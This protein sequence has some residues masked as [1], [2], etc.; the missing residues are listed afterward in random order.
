[1]MYDPKA[2]APAFIFGRNYFL[3]LKAESTTVGRDSLPVLGMALEL[4]DAKDNRTRRYVNVFKNQDPHG[5]FAKFGEA[6]IAANP[7]FSNGFNEADLIGRTGAANFWLKDNFLQVN[8]WAFDMPA[9]QLPN[10]GG[11]L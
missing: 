11:E 7:E 1:M 2:F 9:P 5:S 10:Q 3:I 8:N 4:A 6:F